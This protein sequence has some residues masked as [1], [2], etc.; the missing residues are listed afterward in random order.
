[1]IEA[2]ST[3]QSPALLVLS[4]SAMLVA[5]AGSAALYMQYLD[6]GDAAFCG[7]KSG[8]EA[9]RKAG[10]S[11]VFGSRFLSVPLFG[12]IAYGAV[13]AASVRAPR[14]KTTFFLTVAGGVFGAA[15]LAVQAFYVHAFCWLC[16]TVDTAALVAAGA[17]LLDARS[18]ATSGEPLPRWGWAALAGLALAAPIAWVN[19]KPSP[20]VPAAVAALY[21][22]NKINVV[23]FADFECPFCRAYHPVLQQVLHDYPP[24]QVN[25]LRKHMPLGAHEQ[26]MPAARADVCAEAQGKGEELASRLV[27]IELSPSADRR[28]ALE[29]G[30]DAGKFDSCLASSAPDA[31]IKADTEL[32]ERAGFEGLPTTY[33]GN[34]RLLGAVSEAAVRDAFE[35]A[36]KGEGAGGIPAALYVAC[37]LGALAGVI[38]LAR[39]SRGT[40]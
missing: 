30:V 19:V 5:L 23:E 4:R 40:V 28:A 15:L 13:L 31:R 34:K 7:L 12:L 26:A 36:K 37:V 24:T 38:W 8:C 21:E 29:V 9:V 35:R 3:N 2:R 25:F 32:L 16:A 17:M 33:V 22:P 20:P 39:R 14:S 1:M 18:P 11:Y 6:P 10:F 27:E